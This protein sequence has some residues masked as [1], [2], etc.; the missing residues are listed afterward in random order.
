[1]SAVAGYLALQWPGHYHGAT[2]QERHRR[3]PGDDLTDDPVAVTTHAIMINAPPDRIWPWL[4]QMGWH[5]W[6]GTARA[7]GR[8]APVPGE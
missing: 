7:V 5:R 8:S 3:L 6:A 2:E 4:A 1:M